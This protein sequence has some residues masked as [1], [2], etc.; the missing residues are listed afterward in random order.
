MAA[1]WRCALAAPTA[2]HWP[3]AGHWQRQRHATVATAEWLEVLEQ[4][5]AVSRTAA[6]ARVHAARVGLVYDDVT[7]VYDD[8]TYVY[9]D[10]T[11]VYDDVTYGYMP[12][13]KA[14]VSKCA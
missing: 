1:H 14:S 12:E 5:P 6:Q 9:D 10:V 2:A 13:P 11:Y 4:L 3:T 8:V 7:Y